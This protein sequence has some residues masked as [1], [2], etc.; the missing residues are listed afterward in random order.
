MYHSRQYISRVPQRA[1]HITCVPL[2]ETILPN[3]PH[4]IC[5]TEHHLRKQE[6]ENVSIAHYTLG[7]KFCRQ[8][9]KHGGTSI[10]V[11]ESLDFINIDLQS[12]CTEQDTEICAIKLNLPTISIYIICIYRSPAG[13]F[14]LFT[15]SLD[16]ILSQ[17][18]KPNIEIIIY[19]DININYFD[20]NCCKR[21]QLDVLLATYNL[22]STV[23]FS[24]RSFN[25]SVTAI[26]NIFIDISH[27][28][29]YT[30]GPLINGLSGHDGQIIKLKNINMQKQPHETKIIRNVNKR[31]MEDFKIKLSY[32]IWENIFGGNDVN[33]MF[34]NFHNTFLR[35]FYSSFPKKRIQAFNTKK[36][37][38]CG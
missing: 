13:I 25:G 35:I 7:A 12:F 3:L 30:L 6:I 36:T 17:L 1:V 15:Q 4:V 14:T 37:I 11:H 33:D 18:Y 22:T 21:Q 28:D 24:T 8:K 16:N 31:S 34:N 19:G 20:K 26:Y 23:R 9:L 27:S 32:E 5:L 2:L 10:F 29:K 38:V